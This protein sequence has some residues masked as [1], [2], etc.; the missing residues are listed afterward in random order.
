MDASVGEICDV[1]QTDNPSLLEPTLSGREIAVF[2]SGYT[3]APSLTR[4]S[5]SG[6]SDTM[7]VSGCWLRKLRP[8]PAHFGGPP[9][10]VSTVVQTHI[11]VFLT[12]AELRTELWEHPRPAP[13]HLPVTKRLA[14]LGRLATPPNKEAAPR[15]LGGEKVAHKR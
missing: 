9:V 13:Q 14:V 6:D 4:L 15:V 7:I 12:S 11:R 5:R 1:V 2:V 8:V 3:H 10:L